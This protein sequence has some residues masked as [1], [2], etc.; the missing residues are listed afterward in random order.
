G[1]PDAGARRSPPEDVDRA[2]ALAGGVWPGPQPAHPQVGGAVPAVTGAAVGAPQPTA[3]SPPEHAD[4]AGAGHGWG[5]GGRQPAAQ[6]VR[7]APAPPRRVLRSPPM[8]VGGTG[9][10]PDH[11]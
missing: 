10:E 6:L 1:V 11:D 4:R 8:P 9:P 2:V 3:G 5:R 7:A